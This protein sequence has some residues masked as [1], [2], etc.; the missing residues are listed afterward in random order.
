MNW[1][2]DEAVYFGDAL[3]EGGN[4]ETVIGIIDTIPVKDHRHTYDLLLQYFK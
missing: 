1:N 2:A 4:D 3:Y